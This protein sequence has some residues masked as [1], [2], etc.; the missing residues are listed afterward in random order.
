M[1]DFDQSKRL[2]QVTMPFPEPEL[3]LRS[4]RGREECS[5]LFRFQLELVDPDFENGGDISKVLDPGTILGQL[6][7][8]S[9]RI[10]DSRSRL[11]NGFVWRFSG[12]STATR[13]AT[14]SAELVPW[15]WALTLN[16]QS[17]I[18]QELSAKQIIEK[19]INDGP[20]TTKDFRWDTTQSFATRDYC[21]QY[22]ETDFDF[23]QRLLEE[24]G[25]GYHWEFA[26]GKHTMVFSQENPSGSVEEYAF[27][28]AGGALDLITSLEQSFQ[29]HT[30]KWASKAWLPLSNSKVES[31]DKSLTEFLGKFAKD[32]EVYDH[33]F[34][35]VAEKSS[36]AD[37]KNANVA[38]LQ[39]AESRSTTYRG[40]STVPSFGIANH[41]QVSGVP[42]FENKS[43][44]AL[45]VDHHG[46][47][48]SF[49][50]GS[51]SQAYEN[52]F[53]CIE[54]G[55]TRPPARITRK[56]RIDGIQTAI[57]VGPKGDEIF[58][59]EYG[60]VKVAFH[61][62]RESKSDEKSSCW[63]RVAQGWAGNKFGIYFHP[64]VGQEVIV[65]FL[66]G[67]P[68]RPLI[69]GRVYNEANRYPYALPAEKEKGGLKTQSTT[70]GG[71][72]NFNELRFT[73]TKDKEEIYLHAERDW[74]TVVENSATLKI[75]FDDQDPGD[76]TIDV[77]ND[78]T[79]TVDKG[80]QTVT[81]ST[82]NW[83]N[84]VDKGD[85]TLKVAKG[86]IV[87]EAKTSIE[88]KCG[89][90]SIKLEPTKI[91]MK[92]LQTKMVFEP[93]KAALKSVMVDV[94]GT[95]ST[96]IK[97]PMTDIKGDAMLKMKGGVVMIN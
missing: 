71:A 95:A 16:A 72:A 82:G 86:K 42:H 22:R 15:A 45:W 3:F 1:P 69:T 11:F 79:I 39:Q 31:K 58:T 29:L 74:N 35:R 32:T 18:F 73:D 24:E 52:A 17:R 85:F 66:D 68:D 93:T 87:I 53:E 94:A 6:V 47:D 90:S 70:K 25:C 57:V 80:N 50:A 13:E 12:G 61:W 62:D 7:E 75:G 76:Q 81:I 89:K 8:F 88:L 30:G 77:Y 36:Q 51:G 84:K 20:Y 54:A 2:L 5:R 10:D 63:I 4:F 92:V 38:R 64:R 96:K 55:L 49:F 9:V 28:D 91:T 44:Q 59:D 37:L 27:D 78:R 21:V 65:S 34:A 97:A 56:A 14:Y 26:A 48:S 23:V 83:D 60:R 40:T 41:F 46:E 19:V 43:Y 33:D 67:D